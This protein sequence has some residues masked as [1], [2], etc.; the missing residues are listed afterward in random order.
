M[1]FTHEKHPK[2]S[3]VALTDKRSAPVQPGDQVNTCAICSFTHVFAI[4]TKRWSLFSLSDPTALTRVICSTATNSSHL[5]LG[6]NNVWMDLQLKSVYFQALSITPTIYFGASESLA[7][8]D[9]ERSLQERVSLLSHSGSRQ[10]IPV[11]IQRSVQLLFYFAIVKLSPLWMVE[12]ERK[13]CDF[14][15]CTVEQWHH[16]LVRKI[17]TE[18]AW[19]SLWLSTLWCNVWMTPSFSF[20]WTEN[21]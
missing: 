19:G 16:L 17:M 5:L 20:Q 13:P 2:Y 9:C 3:H 4:R 15:V 11:A 21:N 6:L 10:A 14:T 8:A 7:W 1:N 18:K 12:N